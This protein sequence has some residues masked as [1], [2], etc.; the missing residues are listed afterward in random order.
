LEKI[1]K[2]SHF[3]FLLQTNRVA[4]L[5]EFSPVR[6]LLTLGSFGENTYRS[7]PHFLFF[8][9]AKVIHQF[10]KKWVGA[11][12]ILGDFVT[13]SFCHPVRVGLK[14][15]LGEKVICHEKKYYVQNFTR[16]RDR[17]VKF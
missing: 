14:S 9:M 10:W 6:G 15:W 13:S 5:D 16:I 4:R 11:T 7:S 8:L 1:L 12:L 2:N 3:F 17:A